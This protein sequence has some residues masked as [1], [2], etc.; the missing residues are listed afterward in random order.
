MD[1][2]ALKILTVVGLGAV[3][4]WAAIPAGFALGLHPIA[5]A[6]SAATGAIIAV[7][8][9][10]ALGERAQEW[11]ARRHEPSDGGRRRLRD[12][13]RR[14]GAAGLGLAAP[15]LVGAPL[16]T[17]LGLLLGAPPRSLLVWMTLGASIWSAILTLAGVL[18][19]V[20]LESLG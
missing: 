18:G 7:L 8:V 2:A 19:V 16:G 17:V 3:E 1:D 15:L 12:L 9:V 10:V 5:T 4:L 11:L 14:H 20:G 6:A 13:W